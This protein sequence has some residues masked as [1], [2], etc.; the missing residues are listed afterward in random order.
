MHDSRVS[1]LSAVAS[2]PLS[3]GRRVSWIRWHAAR[4]KAAVNAPHSRRFAHTEIPIVRTSDLD[5]ARPLA[6]FH[7]FKVLLAVLLTVGLVGPVSASPMSVTVTITNSPGPAIPADFSGL[8]FGA[9]AEMPGHGGVPGYLF[10]A[11]NRQLVTL[12]KN[13][14]LHN[15]RLGGTTV[16]GTNAAVPDRVAIDNLFAFAKAAGV[17]VIY[18]LPLLNGNSATNAATARY[19]WGHYQPLLEYFALGN[20]PDVKRYLYPPFGMGTD[21]AITNYACYLYNWRLLAAWILNVV[22]EAKFAGPD[23]AGRSWAA[24]FAMGQ[25]HS[26]MVS[27]ITQH[28]YV[29]GRPFIGEGPEKLPVQ[30]AIDNILST[31]WVAVKYPAFYEATLAPVQKYGLPYRLTEANDYLKG[32]ENASDSFATALWALEYLH[33]WAARGCVGVNFH[34]TEWLKTDTVYFDAASQSCQINPKAYGIKAFEL[35]SQGGV[36]PVAVSNP[37]GLNFSAYAVGDAAV[38]CATVINKE[39]GAGARDSALT[40]A[41]AGYSFSRA[42]AMFLT[43]P[44]GD[45]GAT[46]GMTLG[47][48]TITNN[49]PWHGEWTPLKTGGSGQFSLKIPATCAALVRMTIR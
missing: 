8:S 36:E 4:A 27:L 3:S 10:C 13:S 18:S 31:N 39:H 41:P 42:E 33:W 26:G 23:A 11:T 21:P 14:G 1:V 12:F 16:E 15:L 38:L 9:V 29:G 28:Y 37:D 19:I 22:P 25:A 40:I 44:T 34:N 35:G 48:G 17:K 7:P 45:A 20:E 30:T 46:S 6:L 2:A 32:I 24:T 5:C 43:A 47:G 49:A